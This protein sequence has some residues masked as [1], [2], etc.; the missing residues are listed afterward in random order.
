MEIV[1]GSDIN[2]IDVLSAQ[3]VSVGIII[4]G[5]TVG[6]GEGPGPVFTLAGNRHHLRFLHQ[7]YRV[8]EMGRDPSRA[9]NTEPTGFHGVF[10]RFSFIITQKTGKCIRLYKKHPLLFSSGIFYFCSSFSRCFFRTRLMY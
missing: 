6:L 4:A 5:D 9:Q 1:A 8:A 3:Q 7:L 10:L 2:N